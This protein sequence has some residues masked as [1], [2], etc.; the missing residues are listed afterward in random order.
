MSGK[1]S[2]G[3]HDPIRVVTLGMMMLYNLKINFALF[4][5]AT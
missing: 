1:D 4:S 3:R 5:F 2:E